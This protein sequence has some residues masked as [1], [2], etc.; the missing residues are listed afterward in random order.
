MSFVNHFCKSGLACHRYCGYI[1]LVTDV[2]HDKQKYFPLAAATAV[3]HS[4]LL[5][6][7]LPLRG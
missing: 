7:L 3:S 4:R 1:S 2:I 6:A 5:L